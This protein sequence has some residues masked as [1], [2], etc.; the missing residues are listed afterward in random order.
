MGTLGGTFANV[1]NLLGGYNLD[2]GVAAT[3]GVS[4]VA[5]PEAS[6]AFL[7]L[8]GPAFLPRRRRA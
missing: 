6:S 3:N 8:G 4:L 2:Y 7:A 1:P 5:V